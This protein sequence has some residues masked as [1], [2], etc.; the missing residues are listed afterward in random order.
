MSRVSVKWHLVAAIVAVPVMALAQTAAAPAPQPATIEGATSHVYK[1][2]GRDELRLHVFTSDHAES[3]ARKPAIVFFFGGAWTQ[4]TIMQF[5]PQATHFAERGMVAI[6]ADYR[7]F[8]RHGT[9]PFEAISD[10]KSAL[11]WVRSH[12]AQLG[13]ESTRIAAAGGSAGGHIALSAA[14]FGTFDEAGED[15]SVSS[16]PNALVLFN[17]A[18]DTTAATPAV[19]KERFGGRGREGSPLHHVTTGLPPTL[20]VHGRADA[21]VPYGDVERFCAEA[22]AHGNQCELIGYD[23]A[24]HGFFNP[25]NADGKWFRA[26][27]LDADRFLTRIG[28]LRPDPSSDPVK[29]PAAARPP[30]SISRG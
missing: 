25:Q 15:L 19:L 29:S 30:I 20:I 5:V 13:I 6:V 7:V 27:L 8:S 11:R 1:T 9:S 2:V 14:V 3:R 18:V 24:A 12:A 21:T 26:T 17:P 28:Y 4:G 16:K 10:A 22:K 23:G